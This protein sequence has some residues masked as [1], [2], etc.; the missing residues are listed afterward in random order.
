MIG[1]LPI[2]FMIIGFILL[3]TNT[4]ITFRYSKYKIGGYGF[5]ISLTLIIFGAIITLMNFLS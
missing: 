2:T 3:V 1:I 4:V 5:P